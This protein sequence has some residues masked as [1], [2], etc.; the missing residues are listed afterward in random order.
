[1]VSVTASISS[2]SRVYWTHLETVV[3][4]EPLR[5]HSEH[6]RQCAIPGWLQTNKVS[7]FHHVLSPCTE[8]EPVLLSE[9]SEPEGHDE[10]CMGCLQEPLYKVIVSGK[11]K[12]NTSALNGTIFLTYSEQAKPDT[13]ALTII[14][15]HKGLLP[16][17]AE[18]S[19]EF[20]AL[21]FLLSFSIF[22]LQTSR[23]LFSLPW[24]FQ[25]SCGCLC[26]QW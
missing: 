22:F 13:N 1:M 8:A 25:W 14:S 19:P 26:C 11:K 7:W 17:L 2:S 12:T 15:P 6:T 18:Q 16:Q 10:C 23:F 3:Q 21:C 4:Q 9:G 5:G 24:W 20:P